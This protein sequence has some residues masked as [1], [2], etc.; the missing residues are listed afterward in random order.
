MFDRRDNPYTGNRSVATR[1]ANV[2]CLFVSTDRALYRAA[3]I[4]FSTCLKWYQQHNSH[5]RGL[6]PPTCLVARWEQRMSAG[7]RLCTNVAAPNWVPLSRDAYSSRMEC[8]V[9]ANIQ[10]C[11]VISF[12]QVSGG[13]VAITLVLSESTQF[14][15][16][17]DPLG[18]RM[19]LRATCSTWQSGIVFNFC[20]IIVLPAKRSKGASKR[21]RRTATTLSR[22]YSHPFR[23][24]DSNN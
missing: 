15:V 9:G 22:R 12:E 14:S 5:P 24:V 7:Q 20:S 11:R 2:A 13:L 18:L 16:I 19:G 17:E 21:N 10:A 8:D 6:S 23:A 3:E 1:V 4:R